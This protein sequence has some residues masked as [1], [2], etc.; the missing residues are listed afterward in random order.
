MNGF[1]KK[2]SFIG[3]LIACSLTSCTEDITQELVIGSGSKEEIAVNDIKIKVYPTYLKCG[4]E[5]VIE[6]EHLKNQV[7]P[8][9][10]LSESLGIVDSLKTPVMVTKKVL[11]E[12]KHDLVFE[13]GTD[14]FKV[15]TLVTINAY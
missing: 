1:I 11:L 8:V 5:V 13:C 2:I 6:V 14:S 10:I 4:D 9:V 12:G 7:V 3:L 15:A